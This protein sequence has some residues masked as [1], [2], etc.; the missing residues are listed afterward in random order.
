MDRCDLSLYCYQHGLPALS[1]CLYY[2]EYLT[3]CILYWKQICPA[4]RDYISG[5]TEI[6]TKCT[7]M[8]RLPYSQIYHVNISLENYIPNFVISETSEVNIY[9][10]K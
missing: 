2:C 9:I 3:C 10:I 8:Y 4:F 1:Q 5:I 6:E 7:K